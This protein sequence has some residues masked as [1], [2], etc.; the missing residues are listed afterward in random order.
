MV[1]KEYGLKVRLD[2]SI[3]EERLLIKQ[4]LVKIKLESDKEKEKEKEKDRSVDK[5]GEVEETGKKKRGRKPKPKNEIFKSMVSGW[6]KSG[7]FDCD[8]S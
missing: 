3:E 4:S 1:L 5:S 6:C 8:Y 2:E 7:M